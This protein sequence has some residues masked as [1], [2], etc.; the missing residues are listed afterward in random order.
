[1][2]GI[3]NG[4]LFLVLTTIAIA[5]AAQCVRVEADQLLRVSD[6]P[7]P[8]PV[9]ATATRLVAYLPGTRGEAGQVAS[10]PVHAGAASLVVS[11][12]FVQSAAQKIVTAQRGRYQLAFVDKTN[13]PQGNRPFYLVPSEDDPAKRAI[14]C[15]SSDDDAGTPGATIVASAPTPASNTDCANVAGQRH[16]IGLPYESWILFNSTGAIC[17]A[18]Y[19]LRQRDRL[20]FAMVWRKGETIPAG[21]TANVSNCK[22]PSPQPDVFSSGQIPSLEKQSA[23]V[24]MA[25]FQFQQLGLP[26]ECASESP[27]VTIS[28]PQEGAS[29]RTREH[30]LTLFARY[31]AVFHVGVLASKLR[32]PDFGLQTV[33]GQSVIVN[34]ESEQ[35]GPEYVAMVVIQAIPKAL[36]NRSYPGRDLLHDNDP[37]DRLGLAFSFGLRSPKDRFG[38]GLAYELA[39]G[40]NVV[41]IH[42]WVRVNKL[43]GVSEGQTFTGDIPTKKEWD[44]AWALGLT[45]DIEY[46]TRV[47]GASSK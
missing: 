10:M 37:A 19:P 2:K 27:K 9:P 39:R 43:N 36:S 45:F 35:R 34:K 47:F 24:A 8:M 15:G 41:G 20:N 4:C 32:E 11:K 40:V 21:V 1:M 12:A 38:L 22:T 29:D 25:D 28:I 17:Y 16:L 42:E 33:N 5:A 7:N 3:A 13:A 44:K 30:V 18:P 14:A 46:I 23:T 26:V 6:S 31:S